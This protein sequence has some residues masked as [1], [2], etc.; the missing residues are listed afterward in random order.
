M[1]IPFVRIEM[2]EELNEAENTIYV[3]N[4]NIIDI[5]EAIYFKELK[6]KQE[7]FEQIKSN[8]TLTK[9]AL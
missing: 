5:K 3:N 8:L 2:E 1:G 6:C 4:L 9:L 7:N